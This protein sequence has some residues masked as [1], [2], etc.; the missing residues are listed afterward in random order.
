MAANRLDFWKGRRVLITGHTGFKGSWLSFWLLHLSAE[1]AGFSK[2]IPTDPA[3]FVELNLFNK[4]TSYEGNIQDLSAVQRAL[5]TFQPEIIFHLAA[6]SL[7]SKSYQDP[8]ETINSNVM[9]TTNLLEAVRQVPGVKALVIATSDKCYRPSKNAEVRNQK[10]FSE[11]DALGGADLY[12]A[13]KACA[14]ILTSAYQQAFNMNTL[15]TARAGNVIGGGDWAQD[16]LLPD[17]V[18]GWETK[19]LVLIRQPNF[20]RPWQHVLDPLRGYL[21]LAEALY[22]NTNPAAGAWNFGPI[23]ANSVQEV[24]ERVE[25][26]LPGLHTEKNLS[27]SSKNSFREASTLLLNS[28][29]AEQELSWIPAW[30][31][32]ATLKRTCRWYLERANGV[33][34]ETL[35]SRDISEY[36]SLL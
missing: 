28:A 6:Q 2:N 3:L 31:F 30:D 12:S 17:L 13:S 8:V 23:Q 9:G 33:T 29:K 25:E 19:Q 18:R 10:A 7:V 32:E 20:M 4:M 26:F 11:A 27:G 22:K 16:R 35:C 1:I 15:A 24:C 36:E 14:D 34:A 21:L 5:K